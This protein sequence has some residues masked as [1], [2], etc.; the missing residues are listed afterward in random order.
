M[1]AQR[2]LVVDDDRRLLRVLEFYLTM[3]GFE[4][5]SVA[6]GEAALRLLENDN[7][8]LVILDVMTPGCDGIELCRRMRTDSGMHAVPTLLVT[9][10]VPSQ[11]DV[12]R[13]RLAGAID[14]MAKPFTFAALDSVIRGIFGRDLVGASEER[15]AV[16]AGPR[17]RLAHWA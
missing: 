2:I 6:D 3:E 17:R 13:A 4:M 16:H 15:G 7:F 10:V 12:E 5:T 1:S 11:V 8:G 9:T 14:L